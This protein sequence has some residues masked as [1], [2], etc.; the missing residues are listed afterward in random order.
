MLNKFGLNRNKSKDTAYAEQ[1]EIYGNKLGFAASE[2]YKLLRANLTFSLPDETKCQIIGL[3]SAMRGEGKSTT[4]VNLSY[5]LAQS[6]KKVLLMEGDMRLP[7]MAKRL[8]VAIKPGL[9][10]L[11][12]GMV[13]GN[14][15]VQKSGLLPNL[16]V[17][18]SGDI[19]PNPSEMLGS[20]QMSVVLNALSKV[21]DYIILDLPPVSVV[22]DAIVVSKQLDGMII[23]ARQNYCSKRLLADTI[24]QLKFVEAKILGVVVTGADADGAGYRYKKYGKYSKY[25]KYQ[26]YAGY[27]DYGSSNEEKL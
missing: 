25:D 8:K 19:P 4:S 16:Y 23:V 10:N 22:S 11:L 15:A 18:T 5:T 7:T 2:A 12:A 13:D 21:F 6:G 17:L 24:R 3:T 20:D 14:N 26:R 27:G 9:S 1:A